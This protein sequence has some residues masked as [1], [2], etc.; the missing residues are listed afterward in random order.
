MAA[1][2]SRPRCVI[3]QII[4][5]LWN[6]VMIDPYRT[7][8]SKSHLWKH[9]L[10]CFPNSST[11]FL[12]KIESGV[13]PMSFSLLLAW[14]NVNIS[15]DRLLNLLHSVRWNYLSMPKPQRCGAS[16]E[17]YEWFHLTLCRTY[18]YFHYKVW[19]ENTCPFPNLNGQLVRFGNE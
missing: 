2:L 12:V 6:P 8:H 4:L 13:W 17:M 14:I 10:R 7:K 15:M 18:D 9:D 1:T 16:L 19:D 5:H 3:H 11:S